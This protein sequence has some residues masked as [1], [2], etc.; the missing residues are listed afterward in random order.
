MLR[1]SK[2]LMDRVYRVPMY[3]C[4]IHG[5]ILTLLIALLNFV[6]IFRDGTFVAPMFGPLAWILPK[7]LCNVLFEV[8]LVFTVMMWILIP[9]HSTLQ[10]IALSRRVANSYTWS[11]EKRLLAAF[12]IPIACTLCVACFAPGFLPTPAFEQVLER[13][14]RE[15]F[16]LGQQQH[17]VAYGSTVSYVGINSGR[18]LVDILIGLA[19]VPYFVSYGLFMI[20]AILIRRRLRAFGVSLSARTLKMQRGFHVMQLL[21]GLLPLAIISIPL[22]FFIIGTL[23]QLRLDLATLVFTAFLWACPGVQVCEKKKNK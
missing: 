9:S 13:F 4:A 17:V 2:N 12:T 23:L 14:T 18:S 5:A 7:V 20:L 11:F 16:A 22:I 21:Q 3:I 10:F 1:S 6:H 15:V 8:A 19:I